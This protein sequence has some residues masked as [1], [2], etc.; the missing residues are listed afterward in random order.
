[1]IEFGRRPLIAGLSLVVFLVAGCGGGGGP[2]GD[3]RNFNWS[4]IHQSE[5]VSLLGSNGVM[6]RIETKKIDR[7]RCLISRAYFVPDRNV[8]GQAFF[9]FW[10]FKRWRLIK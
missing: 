5:T 6:Q 3:N 10:P 8:I 1:M 4:A 9:I 2:G 7:N